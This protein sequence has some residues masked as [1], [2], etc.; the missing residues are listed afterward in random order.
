MCKTYGLRCSTF[1]CSSGN[2]WFNTWLLRWM[3]RPRD[4]TKDARRPMVIPT[5]IEMLGSPESTTM[6]RDVG[7]WT[8]AVDYDGDAAGAPSRA[9]PILHCFRFRQKHVAETTTG[10]TGEFPT[11]SASTRTAHFEQFQTVEQRHE[12]HQARPRC[13]PRRRRTSS[14]SRLART[15]ST[16]YSPL[17]YQTQQSTTQCVL[18]T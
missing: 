18:R 11:I 3:V 1:C 2:A 8:V 13:L 14:K 7:G 9:R 6:S 16:R 17:R 5:G 12:C 15:S 10:D 4:C